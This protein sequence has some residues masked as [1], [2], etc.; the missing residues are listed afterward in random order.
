MKADQLIGKKIRVRTWESMAEEFDSDENA[1]NV[2]LGFMKRMSVFCGKIGVITSAK[3]WGN[4]IGV[5]IH[6][7][8]NEDDYRL[9]RKLDFNNWSFSLPM[10]DLEYDRQVSE[11]FL[12]DLKK[13]K[14]FDEALI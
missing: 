7:E 3:D 13:D 1:I 12:H 5:K 9:N 6:F 10:L 8:G 14:V 11:K 4:T 2:P